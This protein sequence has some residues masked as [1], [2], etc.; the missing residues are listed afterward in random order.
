[1]ERSSSASNSSSVGPDISPLLWKSHVRY[2]AHNS[3][4]PGSIVT[5]MNSTNT[6][7][8]H[9]CNYHYNIIH[10]STT[11]S[12]SGPFPLGF[13]IKTSNHHLHLDLMNLMVFDWE[14]KSRSSSLSPLLRCPVSS[15]PPFRLKYL[16]LLEHPQPVFLS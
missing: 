1:M 16:P 3:Q 6:F 2:R 12:S 7:P 5:Q 11:R 9:L 15:P 14:R 13:P 10:P 4:P 8:Y